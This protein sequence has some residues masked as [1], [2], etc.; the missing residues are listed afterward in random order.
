MAANNAVS[1]SSICTTASSS[2]CSESAIRMWLAYFSGNCTAEVVTSPNQNVVMI[3]DLIYA[4]NPFTN[5]VCA[6][7]EFGQYCLGQSAGNSTTKPANGPTNAAQTP[8]TNSDGSPNAQ[9]FNSANVLWLGAN[10]TMNATALC[11]TCTKNVLTS[12][13]QFENAMP[14]AVPINKQ[15]LCYYLSP[16]H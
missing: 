4:L 10:P 7:D 14:P 5:A 1:V 2:S 3:Y 9:A 15:A 12:Y 13:L 16:S 8:L 6:K 11:T